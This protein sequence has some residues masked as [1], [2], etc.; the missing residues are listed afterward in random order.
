MIAAAPG[1][2]ATEK[3]YESETT[4]ECVLAPGVLNEPGTIHIKTKGEGPSTI[5]KGATFVVHNEQITITTPQKWGENLFGIG[6]RQARGFVTVSEIES[7]QATP[8]PVNV[9][10]PAEFEMGLP[11]KTPVANEA[12]TFTVP[13]E[14]RTF[15]TPPVTV[16]SAEGMLITHYSPNRGFTGSGSSFTSTHKGIQSELNG[17]SEPEPGKFEKVIGPL[18]TACTEPKASVQTE[19]PIVVGEVTTTTM[20]PSTTT[21]TTT[22]ATPTGTTTT[23]TTAT[24]TTTQG[25]CDVCVVLNDRLTG[26][27][28]VRKLAQKITL[29][30]GCKF[31]GQTAVPGPFE[32]RITCPSFSNRLILFGF[33]PA[34]V[35]LN[36]VQAENMTGAFEVIESRLRLRTSTKETIEL[37][38]LGLLGLNLPLSCKTAEPAV[39]ALEFVGTASEFINAG[40]STAGET[41]IPAVQCGGPLGGVL[42]SLLTALVSG[43][44][45]TYALHIQP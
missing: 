35:G 15:V 32:G 11:F 38:S 2:A 17:F 44:N 9:A 22:T 5:V 4:A 21:D 20:A 33:L 36:L 18:E 37:T 43:P 6:A 29:P 10:K 13:S 28:A 34:T 40:V 14:E 8:S 7:A 39:L 16:T 24:T 12:V 30:E 26:S 1:G 25:G 42:G 19:T 41:T 3:V 45:N 31:T 27:L 23:T